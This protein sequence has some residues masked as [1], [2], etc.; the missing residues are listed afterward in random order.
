MKPLLHSLLCVTLLA[1]IQTAFADIVRTKNGSTLN[2][3]ITNIDNGVLRL[4]TSFAGVIQM[5]LDEIVG[6]S[7]E[8]EA[9]L[10][11]ANGSEPKGRIEDRPG[12]PILVA[13]DVPTETTAAAI[14]QLWRTANGDP[15]LLAELAKAEVLRKKWESSIAFDLT[16]SSGNA[17]DFGL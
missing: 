3:H 15:V 13:G 7:T 6:F 12:Q 2:G 16:G 5:N 11:L 1:L 8:E 14:R 10:R 17:D 9:F 4:E